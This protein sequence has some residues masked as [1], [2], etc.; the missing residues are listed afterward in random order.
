MSRS[1]GASWL[2]TV[3][4]IFTSP[5][6]M[7]SSPAIIRSAVDFPDPD[8]PTRIMNSP[9][10]M[11]R[12]MF[13]TASK[14]SGYRL[15]S[16]SRTISAIRSY[17]S[18]SLDC[19]RGQ[20]GHDA[21]LEEQY[22][23]DDGDGDE[24]RRGGDVPGGLSE[25]GLAGEERKRGRDRARVVGRRQ[26]DREQEVVPAEDE[27]ED[28]RRECPRGREWQDHPP[29]R[30]KRRR[31]VHLRRLFEVP[32]N[33]AVE[34]DQDV[35][36]E[37]KRERQVRDDQPQIGVVEPDRAPHVEQRTDDRDRGEHR[38]RKRASE[39]QGLTRD[40]ESGDRVGG[41]RRQDDRNRGG[42]QRDRDRVDQRVDERTV[43]ETALEQHLVVLQRP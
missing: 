39:D 11:S 41:E 24:H 10:L 6:E 29:E 15:V 35:D 5:S 31:P 4:P 22:E 21:A 18:L 14:P 19:A 32:W 40:V 33:L 37:R 2:T 1:L 25:L 43:V 8:G 34:S 42:D 16:L 36:R 9:S 17:S 7:S 23:D 12:S 30:L 28:R 20:P 26:R 27:D 3:S 13:R 38:D